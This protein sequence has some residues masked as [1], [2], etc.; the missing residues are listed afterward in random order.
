[1]D[2]P[3]RWRVDGL[4]GGL[5]DG[6][7]APGGCSL[8]TSDPA[9]TTRVESST[10]FTELDVHYLRQPGGGC[11]EVRVGDRRLARV[12]SRGPWLLTGDRRIEVPAGA[13]SVE[14]RPLGGGETRLLGVSF[15]S[16]APGIVYDALGTN[17]AQARDLLRPDAELLADLLQRLGPNLMVLSYGAN[18]L[19][20]ENLDPQRYAA[21]LARVLTRVRRGTSSA[22][23]LTGPPDMLRDRRQPELGPTLRST[24]RTLAAAHGCAYWDAQEAM[25]GR[26][27]I[28]AWKRSGR[29]RGDFVHLTRDGYD[30][31]GAALLGALSEAYSTHQT[32]KGGDVSAR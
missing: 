17:G 27:S 13:K 5:D 3:G 7:W 21:G 9:A 16:G 25:G 18:E 14:L 15:R 1:M 2:S 8:A 4:R 22:C 12:S 30:A 11:F 10:P 24:Q 31:L 19:Y 6:L 20:D 23:L 29:A 28:R 26:N 32:D